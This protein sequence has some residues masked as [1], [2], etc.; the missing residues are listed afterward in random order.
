MVFASN[1]KFA[2]C[3]LL[4]I[5]SN[6]IFFKNLKKRFFRLTARTMLFQGKKMGSIPVKN[7]KSIL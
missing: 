6:P 7:K 1:C 4:I 2:K 3:F 5:G